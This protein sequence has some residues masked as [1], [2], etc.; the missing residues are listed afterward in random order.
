MVVAGSKP[1]GYALV[2]P[3]EARDLKDGLVWAKHLRSVLW[4]LKEILIFLSIFSI[5]KLKF[6][7]GL[8]LKLQT[9]PSLPC[10][11]PL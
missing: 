2:Q 10:T 5:K 1:L 8:L 3:A 9:L 7:G 11:A 4:K 6:L